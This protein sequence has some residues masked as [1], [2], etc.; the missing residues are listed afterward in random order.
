MVHISDYYSIPKEDRK[1]AHIQMQEFIITLLRNIVQIPQKAE[2]NPRLNNY[3]IAEM[4]KEDIMIPIFYILQ[5][6][7]EFSHKMSITI[8]EI[9]YHFYTSFD[10]EVIYAKK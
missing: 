10:P 3:F 2:E 6:D 4:I 9:F 8:L 5:N 1:K 7:Q